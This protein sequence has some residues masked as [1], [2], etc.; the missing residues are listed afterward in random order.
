MAQT[1]KKLSWDVVV[2]G[3]GFAGVEVAD[4]LGRAGV[5]VLLVDANDY[6]QFQPLLY[7]VATAQIG[8]S[9]VARPLRTMFRRRSSVRVTVAEVTAIDAAARTITL[10]DGTE[11]TGGTLVVATGAQANFF[12]IEGAAEHTYPLYSLEDA[13]RLSAAMLTALDEADRLSSDIDSLDLVVVG[14][15]A[16]GVEFAGAVAESLDSA[17]AATF[18]GDLAGRTS[19][20]LLPRCSWIPARR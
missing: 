19:V 8:V 2:V 15:G 20:T 11:C 9:E 7:Q 6:H 18:P 4:R 12:G 1:A 5:E 3:G 14:G 16:T 13:V 10:D 17:V